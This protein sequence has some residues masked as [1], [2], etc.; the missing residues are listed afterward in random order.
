[1]LQRSSWGRVLYGAFLSAAFPGLL[2]FFITGLEDGL[3][4]TKQFILR[5]DVTDSGVQAHRIVMVNELATHS[6]SILQAKG[7][8]GP[9]GLLFKRAMEALQFS[10]ALRIVGRGQHMAGLPE[11]D[12]LLEV[13]RHELAA[14]VGDDPRPGLGVSLASPLQDDFRVGFL[15]GGADIPGDYVT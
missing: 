1:M 3:V 15:H 7:R 11:A 6:Q 10:V 13:A 2:K 12:K 5:S 9:D 4:T 14:A 8:L